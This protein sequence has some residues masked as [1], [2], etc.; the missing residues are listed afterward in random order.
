MEVLR[1][2]GLL[3]FRLGGEVHITPID[4]AADGDVLLMPTAEGNK[5]LGVVMDADV[6]FEI[7]DYVDERAWSVLV[8]GYA[9]VLRHEDDIERA[10]NSRLRSWLATDKQN[11]IEITPTEISTLRS[12]QAVGALPPALSAGPCPD[13]RPAVGQAVAAAPRVKGRF[14]LMTS[15]RWAVA[16]GTTS[17]G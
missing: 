9:K 3:A 7:D 14:V 4:Y 10:E 16:S 12:R 6:A 2:V 13:P 17:A 1:T 8:R 11:L 5:L 15:L